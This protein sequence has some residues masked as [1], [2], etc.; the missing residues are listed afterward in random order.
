[1][2]GFSDQIQSRPIAE[3][4]NTIL[5]TFGQELVDK[6]FQQPVTPADFAHTFEMLLTYG[7]LKK[8]S[9]FDVVHTNK[10][11]E[12]IYNIKQKH[13]DYPAIAQTYATSRSDGS[14]T[15]SL[16]L[17][18]RLRASPPPP[19]PGDPPARFCKSLS[20]GHCKE[21]WL[22]IGSEPTQQCVS[23]A[24]STDENVVITVG[25]G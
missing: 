13:W 11:K 19:A 12:V 6:H 14:R 22:W 7:C 16:R 18:L 24:D 10:F 20:G 1:M 3:I 5:R 23:D 9:I 2:I 17:R 25:V 21:T 15:T 8:K 4:L